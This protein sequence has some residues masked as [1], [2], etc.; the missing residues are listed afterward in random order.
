M[1]LHHIIIALSLIAA[2]SACIAPLD[3]RPVTKPPY[4]PAPAEVVD[5]MAPFARLV[6]GEWKPTAPGMLG[7]LFDTWHWGPGRHS[8]RV[9]TDG[10]GADGNPWR[11]L[12][13][14]YWHP[15][16]KQICLWGVSTYARGVL[17]GTIK[18]DEETADGIFDLYQTVARRKMGLR[19]TFDGPDKYRDV[20][21]EAT[22][23][24][25]LQWMNE[26][27]HIR[28]KG[29][30]APRPPTT[31]VAPKP[32]E[33][34]KALEPL[35][36]HTW[37]AKGRWAAGD[38]FHIQS[39]FEWIPYADG[40]YARAMAQTQNGEPTHLLDAYIYHHTGTNALRCLALSNLGGVYE[41]DIKVLD[42]GALQLD[43]TCYEGDKVFQ[44]VVRIDFAKDGT[45]RHRVWSLEATERTLML[46]VRHQKLEPKKD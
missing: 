45:L 37:E 41:G 32:S 34:L 10:S 43:L 23:P 16:R 2:L 35:L 7:Q 31:E 19:W 14:F 25:G 44:R 6:G 22:G 4:K 27:D 38:V 28:S 24:E 39:A 46:D 11:A 18:F 21:L 3:Q 20:L 33:H 29:P 42:G 36:G 5:P 40:I 8:I 13:V 15:G 9:M 12:R 30:P 17:E 1:R 26:W